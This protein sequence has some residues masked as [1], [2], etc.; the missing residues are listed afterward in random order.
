M[1]LFYITHKIIAREDAYFHIVILHLRALNKMVSVLPT[2][3]ILAQLLT[4]ADLKYDVRLA[5][6]K[7]I[8]HE[9]LF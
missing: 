9:I 7:I 6:I 1:L 4:V 5:R 8:L 2:W 3:Y